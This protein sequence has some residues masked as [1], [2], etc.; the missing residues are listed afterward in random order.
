MTVQRLLTWASPAA[1]KP[2]AVGGLC[3]SILCALNYTGS[4]PW[5]SNH[6]EVWLQGGPPLTTQPELSKLLLFVEMAAHLSWRHERV[7]VSEGFL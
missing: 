1:I 2:T 5:L 3:Y 7:S 4:N 6:E